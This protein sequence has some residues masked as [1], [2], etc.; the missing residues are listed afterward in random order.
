MNFWNILFGKKE[1]DTVGRT[2]KMEQLCADLQELQLRTL[3]FNICVNMVANAMGRCE[4]RTYKDGKEVKAGD[5]WRW[6]VEPN[7]NQNAS[8][9]MHKLVERLYSGNEVLVIEVSSRSD[10]PGLCVAD[11][12]K[13]EKH[14]AVERNKYT[15]VIVGDT[16]YN[17]TFGEKDVLHLVLNHV[18]IKPVLDGIANSYSKAHS[19]ALA[20]FSWNNTKHMKVHVD[21]VQSGTENFEND[22]M[23]ML[24]EQITPFF[25]DGNTVLPEF[26]GYTYTDMTKGVNR[27][28]E[29]TDVR[30][31]A[32]EIFNMTA[33]AFLIPV[34]LS[35]GK[36]EQ[37][38]D[39]H[40]RFLTDVIDPLCDQLAE[41]ANRKIYGF[42]EWQNGNYLTVDS[43]AIIHFDM[44]ANA[45]NIEKL[46]G[47]GAYSIND[48]L[49]AAGHATINEPWA[50]KHFMT[51][52]IGTVQEVLTMGE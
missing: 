37:T 38:K 4:I 8:A 10:M 22:F 11:S 24:K 36:V 47:S 28:S 50:D 17:K 48:I 39:A 13:I 19:A 3:A 31:L 23:K 29:T 12:F 26:D 51:K 49:R 40:T 32:E 15:E 5:Y 35:N 27:A 30:A 16:T 21:Q 25:G 9:F 14:N 44:F 20:A 33:Q 45:A 2:M 43:S 41:E 7:N 1:A 46:V 6:N 34:V 18:N 42:D 52:N